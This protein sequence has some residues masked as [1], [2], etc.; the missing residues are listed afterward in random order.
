MGWRIGILQLTT[1]LD[2]AVEGFKSRL[3]ELGYLEGAGVEFI[4][5][6]VE[7]DVPRLGREAEELAQADVELIFACG[8]PSAK[9][10]AS[11]PRYLPVVFTPVFDPVTAGLVESLQHPG[12]KV[13]GVSGR[14]RAE[15]KLKALC[16]LLPGVR[17]VVAVH[18]GSDPNTALEVTDLQGAAAGLG[19]RVEDKPVQEKEEAVAILKRLVPRETA[20]FL[21]IDRGL[22]QETRLLAETALA[23]G[24]PLMAHSAA[25][26]RAGALLA[27]DANHREL[28]RQAAEMA[29][30]IRQGADPADL[31]VAEPRRPILWLNAATAAKLGVKIEGLPFA[32]ET[33]V[34]R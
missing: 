25:G 33:E 14:V 30:A 20:V 3:R 29:V 5:K 4:Y 31:P 8:T 13:T 6:N 18:T 28:G 2:E 22:E 1:A 17:T 27:V 19:V 7:G 12:G 34:V 11:L 26:V 16:Q 24:L 9:A 32:L 23:Q 15:K 10:A 21:P